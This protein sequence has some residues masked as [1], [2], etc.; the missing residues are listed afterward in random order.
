MELNRTM[1]AG[2]LE[3]LFVFKNFNKKYLLNNLATTKFDIIRQ[4]TIIQNGK[5][6]RHNKKTKRK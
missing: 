1:V 3:V 5:L 6:R 4:N 2:H